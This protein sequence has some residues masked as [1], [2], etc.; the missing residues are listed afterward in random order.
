MVEKTTG[1]DAVLNSSSGWQI[2]FDM[3]KLRLPVPAVLPQI[4]GLAVN[5]SGQIAVNARN[6]ADEGH[7]LLLTP[8]SETAGQSGDPVSAGPRR[9]VRYTVTDLG[10]L[11][12]DASSAV[13]INNR[14]Q[15]VGH[16]RT[17]DGTQ[18]P[19]LW[20]SA[21]GMQDLGTLGGRQGF[22]ESVNDSGRVVGQAE[23]QSGER[24]AF[25]W[26]QGSGIRDIGTLGGKRSDA[27]C[28]NNGGQVVGSSSAT[29][30]KG[31]RIH[32]FLWEVGHEMQDLGAA[33]G[34]L[35]EAD[36][37]NE[38][39]QVVGWRMEGT[40]I[41]AFLWEAAHGMQDLGTLGGATS[42]A[43]YVNNAGQVTGSADTLD[44]THAFLW[45][46][47]RRMQ[48]LGTLG[49]GE[50]YSDALRVKNAVTSLS[51]AVDPALCCDFHVNAIN[52]RGQIAG[53]G[54]NP[55]LQVHAFLLTPVSESALS[56]GAAA[57]Q[58]APNLSTQPVA[59]GRTELPVAMKK[60]KVPPRGGRTSGPRRAIRYTVAELGTLGGEST[61]P[62]GIKQCR[63]SRWKFGNGT[64]ERREVGRAPTPLFGRPKR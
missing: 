30:R 13:G 15:V 32:A 29:T 28:I 3:F 31:E 63:T 46:A 8:V 42:M 22:A 47:G 45:E 5:D 9:P 55:A 59:G 2:S 18:H 36:W 50:T 40:R 27:R 44:G 6:R 20:D 41:H 51:S 4:G 37:I 10:T 16:A 57:A 58:R 12:G 33:E 11:G 25:L 24:H 17:A 35:A 52:D 48:D 53:D 7:V 60:P 23:T 62:Q 43:S 1:L 54:I 34:G 26:Q 14:G 38:R 64:Q 21:R 56:A 19:F 49:R 39:G 61:N